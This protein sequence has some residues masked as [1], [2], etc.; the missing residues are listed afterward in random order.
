MTKRANPDGAVA[1]NLL[2]N[3]GDTGS[4]PGTGRF[5]ILQND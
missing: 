4:T 2:T 1:T 3:V 5:H